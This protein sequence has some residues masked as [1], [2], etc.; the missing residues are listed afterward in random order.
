MLHS[1]ITLYLLAFALMILGCGLPAVA[2]A[3]GASALAYRAE[4]RAVA[5][6]VPRPSRAPVVAPAETTGAEG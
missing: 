6:T 3:L 2:C 4:I 1:Y 5:R